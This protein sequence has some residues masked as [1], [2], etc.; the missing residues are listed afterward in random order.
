MEYFYYSFNI[1]VIFFVKVHYY[2]KTN[3]KDTSKHNV[4]IIPEKLVG[5]KYFSI[6]EKSNLIYIF[7]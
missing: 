3:E 5:Q 6:N 2:L 7:R 4:F 1:M